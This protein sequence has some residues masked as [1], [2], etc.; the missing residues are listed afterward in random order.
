MIYLLL[1]F[2]VYPIINSKPIDSKLVINE[3][4]LRNDIGNSIVLPR[5]NTSNEP[6]GEFYA[7]INNLIGKEISLKK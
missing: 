3:L 7:L 6:V 4:C 2:E 1:V 5:N